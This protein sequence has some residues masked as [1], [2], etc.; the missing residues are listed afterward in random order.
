MV[1]LR[2]IAKIKK[3][4][5]LGWKVNNLRYCIHP[6]LL[7]RS[8]SSGC[9]NIWWCVTWPPFNKKSKEWRGPWCSEVLTLLGYINWGE[10]LSLIFEW[11][12]IYCT[13]FRVMLL[14]FHGL[15]SSAYGS[16]ILIAIGS[17]YA[18]S[19]VDVIQL[20]YHNKD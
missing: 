17:Q 12:L 18:K 20:L 9:C 14:A 2:K 19:W 13:L 5:K 6:I 3:I 16:G 15:Y 7:M 8:L 4:N 11:N 10:W 1:H